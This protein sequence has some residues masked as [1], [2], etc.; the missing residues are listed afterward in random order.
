[1]RSIYCDAALSIFL[2]LAAASNGLA[3]APPPGLEKSKQEAEASGYIFLKSRDQIVA[4]AKQEGKMRALSG[5]DP[6]TIKAMVSVFRKKYPFLDVRVE[7]IEGTE[8][9]QRFVLQMQAGTAKGWDAT[10]IPIDFY[11]EY[12]PFQKKFDILG[13][14]RSGILQVRP[15]MIHPVD[16]NAIGSSSIIQVVAYNRKLM[17]EARVPDN[18]EDFL[19]PELKGKKFL[20]DIR[21]FPLACLV[22]L[23]GLDKTLE[24]SKKLAAQEPLWVRGATRLLTAMI[25]GEYALFMGPNYNSVKRAESRDKTASL[26][27]KA[28]EPIPTRIARADAV[29]DVAENPHAALLWLEFHASA[30]AQE[31]MDRVSP[32]QASI[33]H[34]GSETARITQG[35][36]LSVVDWRH[37]TM[38]REYEEK[39]VG[40]LGFPRAQ[41]KG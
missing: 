2:I 23:W 24:F 7:E 17:P 34:P 10:F 20:A 14:A 35:K 19:K 13:M 40:A 9:Y 37:F 16:R 8:S 33:F 36:K 21:P 3:A 32:Y 18:W 41:V 1:M 4:A 6:D 27:L 29:L 38:M 39:I 12:Q 11:K 15:E 31:I 22:P 28:A 26:A 30:E 25:A 5:L